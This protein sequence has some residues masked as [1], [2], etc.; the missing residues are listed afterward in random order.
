MPCLLGLKEPPAFY[1]AK[2]THMLKL[3]TVFIKRTMSRDVQLQPADTVRCAS[4]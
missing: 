1:I 3:L 4:D 2:Q